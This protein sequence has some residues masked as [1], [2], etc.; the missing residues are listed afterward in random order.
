MIQE[1]LDELIQDWK[2]KDDWQ[3]LQCAELL[4]VVGQR[5]KEAAESIGISE[6]EVANHNCP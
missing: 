5:N 4:F 2:Q 1:T 3:R 6:Q